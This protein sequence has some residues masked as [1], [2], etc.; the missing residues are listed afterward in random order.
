M[1]RNRSDKLFADATKKLNREIDILEIIKKLRVAYFSS[2]TALLPRQRW[3]VSFFDD[4]LLNSESDI[5]FAPSTMSF[6]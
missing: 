6:L 3:L 5:D 2:E 1:Q 4:Y